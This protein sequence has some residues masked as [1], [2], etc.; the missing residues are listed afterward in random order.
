VP[1]P[2]GGEYVVLDCSPPDGPATTCE[3][4]VPGGAGGTQGCHYLL[5]LDDGVEGDEPLVW[6]IWVYE[7]P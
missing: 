6:T 4:P 1:D 2:V 7:G 5:A 3:P